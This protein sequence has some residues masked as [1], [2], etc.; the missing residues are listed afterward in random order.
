M[1]REVSD[2]PGISVAK[3]IESLWKDS[4]AEVFANANWTLA[5]LFKYGLVRHKEVYPARMI[6]LPSRDAI[7]PFQLPVDG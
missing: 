4:E 5:R 2:Y 6:G 1:L 3:V 7:V